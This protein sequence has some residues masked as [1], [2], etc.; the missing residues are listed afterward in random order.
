MIPLID[1]MKTCQT[2]SKEASDKAKHYKVVVTRH[3][4]DVKTLWD[5]IEG[6]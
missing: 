3:E 4:E 5:A 2:L 6:M 1:G